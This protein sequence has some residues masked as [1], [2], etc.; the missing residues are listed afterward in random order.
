MIGKKKCVHLCTPSPHHAIRSRPIV[1]KCYVHRCKH[2][3][4]SITPV[5]FIIFAFSFAQ[6]QQ[7]QKI[8]SLRWQMSISYT[9]VD[10]LGENLFIPPTL[11]ILVVRTTRI[12]VGIRCKY[13]RPA[14]QPEGDSSCCKEVAQF[15]ENSFFTVKKEGKKKWQKY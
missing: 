4:L 1:T 8:F 9:W 5:Y 14:S 2:Y 12:S 13:S 10:S 7:M 11:A 6:P 3:N 15:P